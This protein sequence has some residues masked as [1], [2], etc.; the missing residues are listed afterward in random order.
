M[1]LAIVHW[2]A[3]A[4][5]PPLEAAAMLN[6]RMEAGDGSLDEA[7]VDRWLAWSKESRDAWIRVRDA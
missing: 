7:L 5:L 1:S 6:D 3:L 4:T 2:E